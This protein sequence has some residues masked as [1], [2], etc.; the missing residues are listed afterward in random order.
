MNAKQI[1][2]FHHQLLAL[3]QRAA[4]EANYVAE[5]I[6]ADANPGDEAVNSHAPHHAADN[7]TEAV[8]A[9]V[10]VLESTRVLKDQID[11]ALERME[12]GDFGICQRC[13]A[14]ILEERLS[15][16][17]Y[18]PVCIVCAQIDNNDQRSFAKEN[19]VA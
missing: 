8:D 15:A 17:P 5:A 6:H 3:Q 14:E 13:R 1:S 2:R 7:A 10:R 19:E 11:A 12:R 18:T 4:G 16:L 9:D